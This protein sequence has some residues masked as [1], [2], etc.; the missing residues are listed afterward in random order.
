M[1]KFKIEFFLDFTEALLSFYLSYQNCETR[2]K[3]HE[4]LTKK[5]QNLCSAVKIC[6]ITTRTVETGVKVLK[7]NK[8][9]EW[10]RDNLVDFE[11]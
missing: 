5:S 4:M 10:H 1:F 8:N 6:R 2:I 11:K 7:N 3:I 9:R